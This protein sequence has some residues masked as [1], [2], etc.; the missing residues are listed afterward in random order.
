M[1]RR[2]KNQKRYKEKGWEFLSVEGKR[3]RAQESYKDLLKLED[4]L[5]KKGVISIRHLNSEAAND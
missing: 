2:K 5:Y 3:Q 4:D 1:N